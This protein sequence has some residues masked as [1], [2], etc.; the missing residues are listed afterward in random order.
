VC[1]YVAFVI[2]R[3]KRMCHILLTSA[4]CLA[5][6]HISTLFQTG[7]RFRKQNIEHKMFVL[8]FSTILPAKVLLIRIIQGHLPQMHHFC[9]VLIKFEF[10]RHVFQKYSSI[11]FH[12]NPSSG[13][14]VVP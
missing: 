12:E 13:S 7:Q 11:K 4:A 10:S 2:K 5:L 14:R 9:H 8:I 3:A 1:A 6:P